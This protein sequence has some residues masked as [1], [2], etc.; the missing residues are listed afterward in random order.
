MHPINQMHTANQTTVG[1]AHNLAHKSPL[2]TLENILLFIDLS[3][4]QP[5]RRKYVHSAGLP[6]LGYWENV[7]SYRRPSFRE[8]VSFRGQ[9]VIGVSLKLNE[10]LLPRRKSTLSHLVSIAVPYARV[11]KRTAACHFAGFPC[12]SLGSARRRVSGP[13]APPSPRNSCAAG[14]RSHRRL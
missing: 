6:D 1:D 2:A 4:D 3:A 12:K 7:F 9:S 10:R 14:P 5:N 13:A 11:Y 8:L